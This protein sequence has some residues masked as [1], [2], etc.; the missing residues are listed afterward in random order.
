MFSQQNNKNF[1]S[2]GNMRQFYEK[3]LDL[4]WQR[5][6]SFRINK[7]YLEEFAKSES[8]I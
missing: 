1:R 8:F 3:Y 4:S 6:F 2:Y 5:N 7:L